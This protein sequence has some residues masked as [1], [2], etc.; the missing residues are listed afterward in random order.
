MSPEAA[1]AASLRNP[2]RGLR[3]FEA[4]E[5]DLF[6]GRKVETGAVVE[7][8]HRHR[9]LAVVGASGCGKSSLVRAG[10]IASLRVGATAD[11]PNWRIAI[12]RPGNRPISSLA[13]A[14]RA[15]DA[16]GVSRSGEVGLGTALR[17]G[18][19]GIIES[20]RRCALPDSTRLF[21]LVDQ[22]E[23][24]FRFVSE[25]AGR[26]TEEA[27][28][29][30][31]LLLEASAQ[32]EFEI[33]VALTMRSEYLGLC[34]MFPGLP[35]AINEGMYLVPRMSRDQVRETIEEPIRA[36]GG[37]IAERLI[38]RLLNDLGLLER[39]LPSP[40]DEH[41]LVA[42]RR[43]NLA[44]RAPDQLP[45]LQHALTC[46]WNEWVGESP[47]KPR[48][49][50]EHYGRIGVLGVSLSKHAD[51]CLRDVEARVPHGRR[52]AEILF[53]CLTEITADGRRIRRPA[54][55]GDIARV[56]ETSVEEI[57]TVIE[58]FRAEGRSFLMPPPSERLGPDS[59]V[60]I[61][62]ESLIRQWH[63]L[64][65]WVQ[66]EAQMAD[67]YRRLA[68]AAAAG[69]PGGVAARTG[70]AAGNWTRRFS[71]RR[72]RGP[73]RP[74]RSGTAGTSRWPPS[75]SSGAGARSGIG[76]RCSCRRWAWPPSCWPARS[77]TRAGAPSRR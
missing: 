2:F 18:G 34:D 31:T 46:L 11:E 3:P 55:L 38:D 25:S 48:I 75:S 15:P 77:S 23:E 64:Q 50:V 74:G 8:L 71:G 40:A 72:R 57:A 56:A 65:E 54:R 22:F 19:L 69:R 58:A 32:R 1:V 45:V 16:L 17:R 51:A 63:T 35:D 13:A 39:P 52:N 14:L 33:H 30:V 47:R 41:R 29:F 49:D 37:D 24:L 76:A 59:V 42:V 12:M 4:D 21:I 62:H 9:F 53:R 26:A 43:Q 60:D 73:R 10:A 36:S 20:F 61:S 70:G 5:A 68:E 67:V 44:E 7:R 66:T 6:F 28:A 27:I